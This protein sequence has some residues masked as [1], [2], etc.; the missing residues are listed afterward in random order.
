MT[1]EYCFLYKVDMFNTKSNEKIDRYYATRAETQE[2]ADGHTAMY[3][4][5][6]NRQNDGIVI[7]GFEFVRKMRV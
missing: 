5:W 6:R 4:E 1:V 3:M 7:R 2:Q